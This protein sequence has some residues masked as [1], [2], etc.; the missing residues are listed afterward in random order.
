MSARTLIV[1]GPLRET[2]SRNSQSNSMI[3]SLWCPVFASRENSNFVI[4]IQ[5]RDEYFCSKI[6][7]KIPIIFLEE[8]RQSG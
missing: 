5:A 6:G 8:V 3:P 2:A 7:L 4:D 1:N